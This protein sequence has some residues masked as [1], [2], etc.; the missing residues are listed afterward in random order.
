MVAVMRPVYVWA[1]ALGFSIAAWWLVI[2]AAL[3]VTP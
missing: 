2:I 1:V 3:K